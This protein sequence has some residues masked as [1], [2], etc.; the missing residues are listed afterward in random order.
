[1]YTVGNI[2]E[3]VVTGY[4]FYR[5]LVHFAVFII[6]H[7][8]PSFTRKSIHEQQ[9]SHP[10]IYIPVPCSNM[11]TSQKKQKKSTGACSV[12]QPRDAPQGHIE[13][14]IKPTRVSPL[15]HPLRHPVSCYEAY[16]QETQTEPEESTNPPS[17]L[18]ESPL[19][20]PSHAYPVACHHPHNSNSPSA[21]H[22]LITAETAP[23]SPTAASDTRPCSSRPPAPETYRRWNRPGR[24]ASRLRARRPGIRRTRRRRFRRRGGRVRLRLRGG[25]RGGRIGWMVGG[26]CEMLDI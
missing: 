13:A 14:P 23:V 6:Q 2:L 9:S 10:I 4:I 12:Q 18:A 8:R 26:F 21:T 17:P 15:P 11:L 25:R 24:A 19:P 16:P 7:Q 3:R 22:L 5:N 1:M 20:R